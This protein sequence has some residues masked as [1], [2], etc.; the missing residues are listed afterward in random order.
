MGISLSGFNSGLP[1][2]DLITQLM[3]VER[4]PIQLMELRKQDINKEKSRYDE[5]KNKVNSLL[6][7]VKALTTTSLNKNP[8]KSKLA[9]LAVESHKSLV[10]VSAGESASPQS[11]QLKIINTATN[12][13]ATSTSEV[14]D[15][16]QGATLTTE[17]AQG[18]LKAGTFTVFVDGQANT[19]TV[20]K[21]GTETVD[22][23]LA[24]IA[25]ISG[26]TGASVVNGKI[27][28]TFANG[29]DVRLGAATDTSTFL[30]ATHL[31]TG[32]NTGTSITSSAN[33]L[34][35]NPG[36]VIT[37]ATAN[38]STPVTAGTFTIGTAEFDTTG[39][40]LNQ[41]ISDINNN[42]K[43]GVTASFNYSANKL[44]LTSKTAGSSLIT[45]QN[46]TSNFLSAM[47]LI[48]G[49]DTTTSQ[50]AGANASFEL[51]GTLM[52]SASNTVDQSITGLTDVTMNLLNQE[53]G[54]T[55]NIE[56]KND[57][58]QIKKML[59]DFITKYNDVISFIDVQTN[60]ENKGVLT[61]DS[62]IL[63]LRQQLRQIAS[64][65]IPGLAGTGYENLSDV[66]IYTRKPGESSSVVNAKPTFNALD[67]AMLENALANNPDIIRQFFIGTTAA[68]GF[69]GIMTRVQAQLNG[70]LSTEANN[71]GLFAAYSDT[72]GRRIASIDESIER[73]ELRLEKKESFYKQQFLT[74]ERMIG[75]YQAQG[76]SLNGL[77]QQLSA[78]KR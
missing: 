7:S 34:L 10:T 9:S 13:K 19:V 59:S 62:G 35:I 50:T 74:M 63:R 46:G 75:Q 5:V 2:N 39:K 11:I 8:F 66:G 15:K 18:S 17:L 26:I 23:V 69:D 57:T 51:N 43:S 37:D 61:G 14:G 3:A 64:M 44:E 38:L 29:T 47:G 70:V 40:T 42:S 48:N 58:E 6:T 1:I 73:A 36:A 33:V 71:K 32:A 30:K 77:I 55:I 4:R 53:P 22:D 28:L 20:A 67:T 25:A 52:Y 12:T 54:T 72:V 45:L 16:L 41:I 21:D 56:I 65:R 31:Q 49:A 24:N 68:D 60:A 27:E 78:N 76:T